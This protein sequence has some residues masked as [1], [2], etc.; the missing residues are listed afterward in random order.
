MKQIVSN[1]TF[2]AAEVSQLTIFINSQELRFLWDTL[3]LVDYG[4]GES[5]DFLQP[6]LAVDLK[7]QEIIYFRN[8]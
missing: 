5:L 6:W 7:R 2:S 8:L 4:I 3:Y 1:L